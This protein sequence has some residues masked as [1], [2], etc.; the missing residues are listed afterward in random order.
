MT[1]GIIHTMSTAQNELLAT[2]K[3]LE[4]TLSEQGKVIAQTQ[5]NLAIS[6]PKGSE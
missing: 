2:I 6:E 5:K 1:Y 4:K 3:T